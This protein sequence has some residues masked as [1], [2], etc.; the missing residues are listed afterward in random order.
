MNSQLYTAATGLLVE[1]RRLEVVANNLANVTTQGYRAQR[2]FSTVYQRFAPTAAATVRSANAGVAL[3][4]AY[5]VPGSGPLQ[6]TGRSLDIALGDGTFLV[7][8]TPFGP[9]YTRAGS[10]QLSPAGELTDSTGNTVLGA[11]GK[12]LRGLGPATMIGADGRVL[13]GEEVRGRLKLVR[14]P[15]GVLRREGNALL[16]AAGNDPALTTVTDPA[17]RPGWI[18]KSAT[19]PLDELVRMIEIQRAFQSYEKLISLTMNEV[20]RRAVNDLAG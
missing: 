18:E 10:L 13:D 17:V 6:Q 2:L 8:S 12:P 19:R 5:D 7:V 4:G 14:D 11:S 15:G 16:T 20:N 1:Q 9:R 3:A